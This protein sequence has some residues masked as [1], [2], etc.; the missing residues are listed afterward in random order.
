MSSTNNPLPAEK[1]RWLSLF[2]ALFFFLNYLPLL[3][4]VSR[5]RGDERFYTDAAI[6]MVQSGDY[7]TPLFDDDT[8]RFNKPIFTYWLLVASYRL[9]G[10][11]FLTSR[12]PFLIAGA[13]C[14]WL[15]GL[16][17]RALFREPKVGAAAAALMASN[18]TVFHLAV[19]STPD[20]MLCLFVTASLY[21]FARI[22]F[23]GDRT[24]SSFF[25][26]Y[27]G[28]AL[29][30]E[31]KGLAGVLPVVFVCLYALA[32]SAPQDGRSVRQL[33]YGPLLLPALFLA[34]AWYGIAWLVHGAEAVTDFFNDQVGE[35]LERNPLVL[36]QNVVHYLT[37]PVMQFLPWSLILA[38]YISRAPR[39]AREA[40]L[41]RR[42]EFFFVLGWFA[43]LLIVFTPANIT[44]SRYFVTAY[45]LLAGALAFVLLKAARDRSLAF[46][47]RIQTGVKWACVVAVAVGLFLAQFGL[48]VHPRIIAGALA[49]TV[50]A[51]SLLVWLNKQPEAWPAPLYVF[52]LLIMVFFATVEIW[53]QPVFSVSPAPL[54]AERLFP[55]G[56]QRSFNDNE[57]GDHNCGGQQIQ[58]TRAIGPRLV[59]L[60]GLPLNYA[61]QLRV[62]SGGRLEPKLIGSPHTSEILDRYR[63]VVCTP[64]VLDAWQPHGRRIE[65]CGFFY[66]PWKTR[67]YLKLVF[68]RDKQAVFASK[69]VPCLLV[70]R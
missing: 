4:H 58:A 21:G 27:F 52:G 68:A 42:K 66:K 44:R 32:V 2:F 23:H 14:V 49:L 47:K 37:A 26:A 11:S 67:D 24:F 50:V 36:L 6:R 15:T 5:W 31:V 65:P 41:A 38:V 69:T 43:L 64:E 16:I 7:V 28:A 12:L 56:K 60:A 39:S 29:A 3:P 70:A 46:K 30:V 54:I 61:S 17:A 48:C 55:S 35:R 34:V 13:G 25:L 1:G 59:A 22:L 45:P 19:R 53:I 10:I 62:A 33:L 40:W 9:F 63:T 51:G 57:P 18:Y 20:I 8:L